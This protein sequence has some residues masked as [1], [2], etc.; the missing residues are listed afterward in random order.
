MRDG[1]P[2]SLVVAAIALCCVLPRMGLAQLPAT[3]PTS[4]SPSH[5]TADLVAFRPHPNA[6]EPV[7]IVAMD[8]QAHDPRQ[9]PISANNLPSYNGSTEEHAAHA[10]EST[11]SPDQIAHLAASRSTTARLLR[12]QAQTNRTTSRH[13]S[14]DETAALYDC[15]VQLQ[16]DRQAQVSAEKALEAYYGIAALTA[17]SQIQ[18]E[19]ILEIDDLKATL[20][21]IVDKGLAVGDLTQLDRARVQALD[22]RLQSESGQSKIRSQLSLLIGNECA[23]VLQI[24]G[25]EQPSL[26]ASDVCTL[27]QQALCS[28]RDLA[29]W[30]LLGDRLNED[31]LELASGALNSITMI[32][33]S[34]IV[35]KCGILEKLTGSAN[36]RTQAEV[37]N[38]QRQIQEFE[39]SLRNQITVEVEVAWIDTTTALQRWEY[40]NQ[41]IASWRE[42][43][44]QLDRAAELGKAFPEDRITSKLELKKSQLELVQRWN[45]FQQ[46]KA[47]LRLATGDLPTR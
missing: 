29:A 13:K 23:C 34:P 35:S 16:A 10:I 17:A 36:A 47:K 33:L 4:I 37:R 30:V 21:S 32:P 14:D 43:L 25:L 3:F 27:I 15:F 8:A 28:R 19:L 20:L 31:N 9:F 45:D 42:R 46:A 7:D 41:S 11:L 26:P 24:D 38:R 1:K 12:S 6:V 44:D 18:R 39:C 22:A 40:A 5:P 2:F